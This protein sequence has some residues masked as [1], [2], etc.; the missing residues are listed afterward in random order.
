MQVEGA[1]PTL[2]AIRKLNAFVLFREEGMLAMLDAFP[3]YKDFVVDHKEWSV[4]QVKNILFPFSRRRTTNGLQNEVYLI[5][6]MLLWQ[7]H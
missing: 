2:E 3:E 5:Q 7:R 4:R 6:R 1:Q